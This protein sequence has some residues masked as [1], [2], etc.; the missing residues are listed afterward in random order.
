MNITKKFKK[1]T[2]EKTIYFFKFNCYLKIVSNIK[3]KI[4]YKMNKKNNNFL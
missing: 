3:R 4:I 2:K 1:P